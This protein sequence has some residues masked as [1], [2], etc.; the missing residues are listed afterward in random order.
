MS[1]LGPPELRSYLLTGSEVSHGLVSLCND[2]EQH[3]MHECTS[4]NQ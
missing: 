4:E 3:I 1:Y 2:T